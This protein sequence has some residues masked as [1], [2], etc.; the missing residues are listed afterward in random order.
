[1][2][3]RKF[4]F[5]VFAAPRRCLVKVRL[6]LLVVGFSSAHGEGQESMSKVACPPAKQLSLGGY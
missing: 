4:R 5:S 1:M 2:P 6:A 3:A